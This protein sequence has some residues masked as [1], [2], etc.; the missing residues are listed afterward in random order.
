[1]PEGSAAPTAY[2]W[3][4]LSDFGLARQADSDLV[5][6][7]SG[8]VM[9]TPG[10]MAPEQTG[11]RGQ[12]IGPATDVYGLGAI[13]Y[14]LLTGRP[15]VTGK[16]AMECIRQI[17]LERPTPPRQ[18]CEGV[19]QALEAICLRCLAKAPA[20]RYASALALAEDLRRFQ[21]GEPVAGSWW[22]VWVAAAV[23]LM[24]GGAGILL[25]S[26]VPGRPKS[27][28]GKGLT[29]AP[30]A[31]PSWKG[32]LDVRVWESRSP[33]PRKFEPTGQRQA[34]SLAQAVPLSPRDWMR[35][36]AKL[37]RPAYLYVIWIDTEG[38]ATPIYPWQDGD[39]N[40]R[41][42]EERK[43][44]RLNLPEG[45]GELAPLA[46]GPAGIETLV[47]LARE[48]ALSEA[49]NASMSGLLASLPRADVADVRA[50]AWF[51][52]GDLVT[53]QREPDRGSIQIGKAQAG[54]DPVLQLQGLLQTKLRPLFPYSRAVCFGNRGT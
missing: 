44:D 9:G 1:V 46:P 2:G 16:S 49:E 38:K 37:N 27:A 34:I 25:W 35:I 7:G 32:D 17:C 53:P 54:G 29:T 13:L 52:D 3:P 14:E 22:L 33:D 51:D 4:K 28:D 10:Y 24:L 48:A 36:E 26:P 30:E 45:A 39:W 20:D 6:T 50:V 8:M 15:P 11:G 47:L 40:K 21:G 43:R 41:P 42:A 5:H 31:Q 12:E 23:L 18:L 19:P